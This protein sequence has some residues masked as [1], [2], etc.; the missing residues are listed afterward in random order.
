M[1]YIEQSLP[2]IAPLHMLVLL[3]CHKNATIQLT[4]SEHIINRM[5][6]Q[7]VFLHYRR[8]KSEQF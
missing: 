3:E 8:I 2:T 4:T 7:T 6:C 1:N 5:F